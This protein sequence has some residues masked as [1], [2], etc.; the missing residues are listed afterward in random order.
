MLLTYLICSVENKNP[1][2]EKGYP[3]IETTEEGVPRGPVIGLI[4]NEQV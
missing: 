1:T 3:Y 4:Y 2:E